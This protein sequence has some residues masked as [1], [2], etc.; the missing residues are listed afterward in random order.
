MSLSPAVS[1]HLPDT[2]PQHSRRSILRG[3]AGGLGTAAF[4]SRFG[5][6]AGAQDST[7]VASPVPVAP[8]SFQ[9][10]AFDLTAISDGTLVFPNQA[11]DVPITQ[12]YFIDAP[13]DELAAAL[14]EN[15][16]GEWIDSPATAS[17]TGSITPLLIDT[18][19]HLVLIDTGAGS[20]FPGAGFLQQS[21][22]DLGIAPE[23]ID[24]VFF[25]HAHGD[26]VL[27]AVDASGTPAFSNARYVMAKGEHRFWTDQDQVLQVFPDV[28]TVDNSP[29]GGFLSILPAIESRLELVDEAR[30]EEIV[31]GLRA[32]SAYGHTP[33]HAAVIVESGEERLLVAGDAFIHPLHVMYPDW[34]F[35]ADTLR[36]QTDTTR[37]GLYNRAAAE[38]MLVH[39]YHVPFPGL[40]H[41]ASAADAFTWEPG[42]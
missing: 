6:R 29:G 37:R 18:G 26:H 34:N 27:G 33:G 21:L 36:S 9:V 38:K 42:R 24:T 28:E 31:P 5:A 8:V 10:G 12:V 30:E 3:V 14:R 2:Q 16:R 41:V 35:I 15:G 11:F 23:A 32:I 4:T 7:P 19:D 22:A 1:T 17:E 20:A 40:G 25:T 39:A 13:E